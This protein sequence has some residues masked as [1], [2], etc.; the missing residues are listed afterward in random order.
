[1]RLNRFLLIL[2]ALHSSTNESEVQN[3][4]GKILPLEIFLIRGRK[5]FESGT[6]FGRVYGVE[7]R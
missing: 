3:K 1:M 5:K 2:R 6:P 4:L 7:D